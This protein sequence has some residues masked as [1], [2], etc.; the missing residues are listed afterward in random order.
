M[1]SMQLFL[2]GASFPESVHVI[3]AP[4]DGGLAIR[5][6]SFFWLGLLGGLGL[7]RSFALMRR[8]IGSM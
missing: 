2:G 1:M 6:E 7:R 5:V 3:A 4:D 8:W